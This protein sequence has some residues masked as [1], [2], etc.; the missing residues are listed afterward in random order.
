VLSLV[1]AHR[2]A[3]GL[4]QLKTSPTLEASAVWKAL[5]M[6]A[7]AYMSHDDPAPPVA[8]T[9]AQ[10]IAACGYA[11]GGWGENIA[12]G[13]AT[14]DSVMQ[15]WLNSPGHRAN[16]ENASYRV[17]GVGAAMNSAGRMYWAQDFGTFDDSGSASPPPPP[18]PPPPTTTTAKAPAPQPKPPAQQPKPAAASPQQSSP[19]SRTGASGPTAPSSR[20]RNRAAHRALS[21]HELIPSLPRTGHRFAAAVSVRSADG[22]RV[23]AGNVGCRGRIGHR[24]LRVV[25]NAFKHGAAVC[26]WRVPRRVHRRLLRGL[27]HVRSD[28]ASAWHLF[29]RRVR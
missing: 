10:R 5:H 8:R 18:P 21:V 9:A 28:G 15:G 1:N 20:A 7:Y 19:Q 14:P 17:I 13:Y 27:I 2:A 22:R 16:I 23:L 25:V 26:A 6:A 29:G 11:G 12:Y 3:M 24:H 4:T